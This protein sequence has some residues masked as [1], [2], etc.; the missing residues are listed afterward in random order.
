MICAI[1][2]EETALAHQFE[3][4]GVHMVYF[5]K[6]ING[7]WAAPAEMVQLVPTAFPEYT[8]DDISDSFFVSN[9]S[10]L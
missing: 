4:N 5:M 1:V 3:R 10:E 6:M 9:K 2:N 7:N 8:I